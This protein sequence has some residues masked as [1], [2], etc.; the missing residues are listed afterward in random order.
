MDEEGISVIDPRGCQGCGVC[1]AE[2][3][4]KAISMKH[5]TDAQLG[6]HAAA[7]AGGTP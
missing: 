2:C 4:A 7:A 5:Y 6:A 3:P 1:V